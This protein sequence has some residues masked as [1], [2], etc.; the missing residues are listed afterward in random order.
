MRTLHTLLIAIT[1]IASG[2]TNAQVSV[3]INVNVGSPPAW[4]P[5][6]PVEVRYYYLPEIQ[7]YYDVNTRHY[8]YMDNGRWARRAYL[9]TAYRNY[10]LYRGPKVVVENYY[11]GS[12]YTYYRPA[13]VVHHRAAPV[14]RHYDKHHHKHH[15]KHHDRGHHGHGRGRH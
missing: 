1:L 3:G 13:R 15:N 5:P 14:V 4:A 2:S 11:G 10:N 6:A 12:P 7:T 8:I 9:P